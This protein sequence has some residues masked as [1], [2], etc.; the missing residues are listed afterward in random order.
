M[1][2]ETYPDLLRFDKIVSKECKN[3]LNVTYTIELSFR[4]FNEILENTLYIP[5]LTINKLNSITW[6]S[7]NG[8]KYNLVLNPFNIKKNQYYQ[9]KKEKETGK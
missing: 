8:I 6:T 1:K 9:N 2:I 5:R 7:E 3:Y 4:A